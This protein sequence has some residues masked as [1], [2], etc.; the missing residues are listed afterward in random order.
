M[1]R[2]VSEASQ[3]PAALEA[4]LVAAV[5]E[6]VRREDGKVPCSVCGQD[7]EENDSLVSLMGHGIFCNS[8]CYDSHLK[9]L[10]AN[11]PE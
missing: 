1:E 3:K 8:E 11:S 5:I 7:V 9:T 4:E 6:R 2:N 10:R